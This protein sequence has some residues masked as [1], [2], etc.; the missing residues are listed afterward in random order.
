MTQ[1]NDGGSVVIVSI[2]PSTAPVYVTQIIVGGNTVESTIPA[3]T[4][5]ASVVPQYIT[6]VTTNGVTLESTVPASTIPES[7]ASEYI[8]QTVVDGT[9][10]SSTILA[11]TLPPQATTGL[12]IISA[13]ET[14]ILV[15]GKTIITSISA[16]TLDLITPLSTPASTVIVVST[17]LVTSDGYV[18]T[19]LHYQEHRTGS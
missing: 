4:I 3:S 6:Q 2:P 1:S 16:S 14:S 11:P 17:G 13:Y 18:N 9:T 8:I 19:G 5:P 7:I 15:S 12:E 10:T